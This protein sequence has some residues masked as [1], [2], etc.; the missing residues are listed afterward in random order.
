MSINNPEKGSLSEAK[1]E[2]ANLNLKIE[3][4]LAKINDL[5]HKVTD[6]AIKM[7]ELQQARSFRE[8]YYDCK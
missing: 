4:L 3:Q 8:N 5:E 6:Y 2:I 1:R 7:A